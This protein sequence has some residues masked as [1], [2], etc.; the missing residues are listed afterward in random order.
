MVIDSEVT[1]VGPVTELWIFIFGQENWSPSSDASCFFCNIL[2]CSFCNVL[3]FHKQGSIVG[4]VFS[5]KLA[6]TDLDADGT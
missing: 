6:V 3:V 4:V 1:D 5:H 2:S